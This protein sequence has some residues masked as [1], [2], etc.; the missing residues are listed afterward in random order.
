MSLTDVPIGL[1]VTSAETGDSILRIGVQTSLKI[2]IVNN[3]GA[4]IALADG[5]AASVFGVYLPSPAFFTLDQLRAMRVTADGWAGTLDAPN[6]AINISCTQA[7][8]WAAGATLTFTI[9]GAVSSGPPGTDSVTI[10]PSNMTGD[11]PLSLEAPLAVASPAQAGEPSAARRA[12]GNAG[13]P[14]QRPAFVVLGRPAEQHLVPDAQERRRDRAG[15]RIHAIREPPSGKGGAL[16]RRPPLRT[17]L[18]GFLAHG[19][20]KPL[21]QGG[22][23]SRCCAPALA[24]LEGAVAGGVYQGCGN[25]GVP[26]AILPGWSGLAGCGLDF[27]AGDAHPP[28]LPLLRGTGQVAGVDQGVAA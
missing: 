14:G 9:T 12:P 13:Q 15:H 26:R 8:T 16:Q 22:L 5:A 18:A 2:A 3:S 20:S 10:V 25:R 7:G 11:V 1:A 6:V 23:Q 24:C 4:A 19:S 28:V 17:V 27:P 21:G